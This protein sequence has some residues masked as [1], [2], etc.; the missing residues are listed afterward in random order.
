MK[1]ILSV[2]FMIASVLYLSA[3]KNVGIGT[4]TPGSKLTVVGSFSAAWANKTTD[5]TITDAD[6]YLSFTG[7]TAATFTLPAAISGTGNFQG[8]IYVIKNGSISATLTIKANGTELIDGISS[9]S[10]A[11][12]EWV[13]F[14]STGATGANSTWNAAKGNNTAATGA[15]GPT[16]PTGTNGTPG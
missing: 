8:R 6:Y 12:G 11:P 7:T 10:I 5:Y 1:K 14:I 4:S 13:T 16:G 15:T 3:Q 2:L 9:I